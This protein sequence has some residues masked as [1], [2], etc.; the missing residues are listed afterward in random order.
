MKPYLFFLYYTYF[1]VSY[2]INKKGLFELTKTI[3]TK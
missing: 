1:T 2:T 3:I